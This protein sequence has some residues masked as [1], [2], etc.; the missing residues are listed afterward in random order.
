MKTISLATCDWRL[1]LV[2]P[3]S[4]GSSSEVPESTG[5]SSE[6]S[7]STGSSSGV[8]TVEGQSSSAPLSIATYFAE[9]GSI[10]ARVPGCVH[11]DLLTAGLIPDPYLADN[12]KDLMWIG[13]Q[14]WRY[15]TVLAPITGLGRIDLVADGLD[16]VATISL[17]GIEV[18]RTK[19]Q[20]RTY[21]FNLTDLLS[22]PLGLSRE[23]TE[24]PEATGTVLLSQLVKEGKSL[25][26]TTNEAQVLTVE[27]SSIYQEAERVRAEAGDYP[28]SYNEPFN[29]T[30]K[31]ASNFGWDWGPTV[32]TAGIWKDL[33]LEVWETARLASVRPHVLLDSPDSDH[34]RVQMDIDLEHETTHSLSL[35]ERAHLRDETGCVV[36]ET[37]VDVSQGQTDVVLALDAGT[38]E[39]WWPRGMGPQTLYRLEVEILCDDEVLDQWS[40]NI[41]FRSVELVSVPDEAGRSF[42]FVVAGQPIFAKGFNW[43]PNDLLVHRVTIGDYRARLHDAAD[44]GANLIRVWGG[45]IFEKDEFYDICDELGLMVWQDC[46]FACAAY[47]ETW[48]FEKEVE[49]EVRDNAVR[50]MSHPSLIL[51]NGCNENLWGHEDWGWKEALGSKGWGAKYYF[52]LLPRIL[53]ELDP[54]RPYWPGSPWSG[55]DQHHPDDPNYGCF[56]SWSVW[57]ETDYVHYHD[58]KPRF[59][60]EFGWCG[61]AAYSTLRDAVGEEHM[62]MW[63]PIYMAHYKSQ[64]GEQK[65]R[66]AISDGF[67]E[68]TNFDTWH[69]AQQIQQARAVRFGIDWWRSLD[70]RCAGAV[71]WQLN[72]CWPVTSWAAVDSSGIRK[73]VWYAIRDAF[74]D[75]IGVIHPTDKGY[76]LSLVNSASED[77][78]AHPIVQRV[79]LEGE[80]RAVWSDAVEVPAGGVIRIDLPDEMS[81]GWNESNTDAYPFWLG[82]DEIITVDAG[83]RQVTARPDKD[84]H[85]VPPRYDV[86]VVPSGV[87]GVVVTVTARTVVRDLLLQTDRL[88]GHTPL[89][90]VTLLP[91][92]SHTWEITGLHHPMTV[93]DCVPPVLLSAADVESRTL[94][95]LHNRGSFVRSNVALGTQET[96]F[97]RTGGDI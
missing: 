19:N 49:A 20:H 69:Y 73:P 13:H 65:L 37:Q 47:P 33:R 88:G 41:G 27:F 45:G 97:T 39:R 89:E 84:L 67:S 79:S 83:P 52:D 59:V 35:V 36:A 74:A 71:V 93:A 55:D 31:M 1:T 95:P 51:W 9:H 30:R 58:T 46:L 72:D 5:S 44:A 14:T 70:P 57:N 18:G 38:V 53:R 54:T 96:S 68:P 34:G 78:E 50:L 64:D 23:A 75:Q 6:L 15:E 32:V 63:D 29:L 80:V 11:D 24:T 48:D 77:W 10:P 85:H 62:R 60:S 17:N 22:Q 92:E 7:A 76:Q 28:A 25:F 3:P 2:P 86:E 42:G 94:S 21:R 90:P 43:I 82:H 91:G 4:T 56:H 12:E 26:S 66:R 87:G 16:T 8:P 40:T 61:P 81:E